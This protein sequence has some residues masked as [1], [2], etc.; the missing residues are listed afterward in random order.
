MSY[1]FDPGI[2]LYLQLIEQLQRALVAGK[3]TRGQRLKPVRELAQEWG[4]TPN[5]MQRALAELERKELIRTERTTGKFVTDDA[6]RL[7]ALREEFLRGETKAVAETLLDLGFSAVDV[8]EGV[9]RALNE[10]T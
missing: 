1:A 8:L 6:G 10:R 4:V 5:T 9:R 7:C 3:L 2:P